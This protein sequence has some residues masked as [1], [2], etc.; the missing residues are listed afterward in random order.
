MLTT[1]LEA[2]L[3]AYPMAEWTAF[4][5]RLS[6]LPQFDPSV[7]MLRRIYVSGAVECEIDKLGRLLIPQTLRAHAGLERKALWA[8]M[9]GYVELWCKTRF[10]SMQQKVLCDHEKRME[11]ASRLSELGL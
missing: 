8:G 7:S 4:E 11:L 3:V 10:D 1:G 9:G 5:E 6:S 2:C